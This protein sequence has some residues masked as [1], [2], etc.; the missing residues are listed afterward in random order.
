[1]AGHVVGTTDEIGPGQR[2][3]VEIDGRSIGVFNVGGR[4]YALRN[5]CPHAGAR[6]CDGKGR[7]AALVRPDGAL[8]MG[9]AVGSIHRIGAL[10]QGLQ[11]CNGWSFWHLQTPHGFVPIDNLRTQM[12]AQ[13]TSAS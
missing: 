2:K 3:I 11:A 13:L 12:R 6:L 7:I 9:D 5:Q 8:T 4:Y 10:A 1:M